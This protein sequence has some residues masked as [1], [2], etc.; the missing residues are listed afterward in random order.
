MHPSVDARSVRRQ[1]PRRPAGP[2]RRPQVV[3]DID[4]RPVLWGLTAPDLGETRFVADAAVTERL[5]QVVAL[6][7]L[8]RRHRGGVPDPRWRDGRVAALQAVRR[9]TAALLV[10]KRGPQGCVAFPGEVGADFEG[11]VARAGFDIE[12][13]STSW[14]PATPS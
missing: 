6:C 2:R 14:A 9:E 11:G 8:I 13:V 7:D 10:C 12:G 1:S 4:Y 3:F 5:L